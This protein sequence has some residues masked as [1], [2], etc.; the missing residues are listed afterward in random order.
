MASSEAQIK[1]LTRFETYIYFSSGP[2]TEI[3]P[4]QT[5]WYRLIMLALHIFSPD[6]TVINHETLVMRK[7]GCNPGWWQVID[8][9]GTPE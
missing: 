8:A 5:T 1:C 9:S 7:S 6:G 2:N 3:I 4:I